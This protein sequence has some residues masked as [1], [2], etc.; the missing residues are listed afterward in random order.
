MDPEDN[1]VMTVNINANI[2]MATKI[3]PQIKDIAHKFKQSRGE[4]LKLFKRYLDD[5]F[6]IFRGTT[7]DLHLFFNEVNQIHPTIKMTINHTTPSTEIQ[8]DRC[9]CEPQTMIPFLDVACSIK[10]GQIVTDLYRK[11]TDRNQ[12]LLTSSCHP[13]QTTANI[14]FSLGLRIVRICSTSESRDKRLAELKGLLL[15][16]GY[17][18]RMVNSAV[19]RARAIPRDIALRKVTHNKAKNRPVFAVTYD[20]RLPSIQSIQAKHWRSM[21]SQDAYLAEVFKEQP[22]TA[23]RRQRNIWNH[24]I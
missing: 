17:S 13:A 2:F 12:Y 9:G 23:F 20:P 7:K 22:L 18:D 3:D 16:R 19:D 21:T 5:F 15:S 4:A 1:H 6:F 24:I 8:Q 10:E 11:E 14:P